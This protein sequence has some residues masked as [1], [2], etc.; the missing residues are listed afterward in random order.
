MEEMDVLLKLQ[1][2][3]LQLNEIKTEHEN[4]PLLIA[5]LD[6]DVN[7]LKELIGKNTEAIQELTKVM[8][9]NMKENV[10]W[11]RAGKMGGPNG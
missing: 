8:G 11:F 10:K 4:I 3:D 7:E 2:I 9:E 6:K 1:E 5:E